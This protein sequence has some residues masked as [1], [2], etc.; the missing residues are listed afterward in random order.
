MIDEYLLAHIQSEEA[1]LARG[2]SQHIGPDFDGGKIKAVSLP[3]RGVPDVQE[4]S[5]WWHKDR[6]QFLWDMVPD[7]WSQ[8]QAEPVMRGLADRYGGDR[9][10]TEVARVM[11]LPGFRNCKPGKARSLVTWTCYPDPLL[12]MRLERGKGTVDWLSFR[13]Q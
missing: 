1:R 7:Q 6:Y 5:T 13:L 3:T 9:G 11:R 12:R 4:R 8:G 2:R 10:A